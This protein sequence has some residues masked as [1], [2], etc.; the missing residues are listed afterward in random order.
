MNHPESFPPPF[1]LHQWLVQPALNRISG[2]EGPVQ[3][4]PRVMAVLLVLA[5]QPGE[6][7]TRLD[8]LDQVWG[9]AVVGEEILTRAISE[10]RRVFGDQA[11][12][13]QYIETIRNNGYRLIAP[14]SAP[15][16][17]I[18]PEE[19]EES[20]EP[21]KP[22]VPDEPK[23][24]LSEAAPSPKRR[25]PE[26]PDGNAA[27]AAPRRQGTWLRWLLV[28]AM[29]ATIALWGP[30][31]LQRDRAVDASIF[32]G[33]TAV[34]LTA[35]AGREYHP[36]LSP[37]GMRVAFAWSGPDDEHAAIH[38][39]QRNSESLLRLS[40]EPG[41]AAWPVWSPDGQSVAFVQ[42]SDT[43]STICL[44]PSIGGAVRRLHAVRHLIEGLDWSPDGSRLAFSA[45]KPN[46][47]YRL[48]LLNL[49]SLAT[50]EVPSDRVDNGG[51]FQPRFSPDGQQLAWIG[52]DRTGGS[53]VFVAPVVGGE[54]R[55]L[56]KGPDNR[57]GLAWTAD[58][59]ALVYAAA[60][61]GIFNLWRAPLDGGPA[62]LIP[63]PGDFAWNP[64]I[65][66]GSGDLVYEQVRVD[67]DL[68]RVSLRDRTTWQADSES[69]ITSTRWETGADFR[70]DG[71]AIA[72][73]SA[74][75]GNPEIWLS[76]V[77]GKNMR[78]L[79]SLKA[80]VVENLRWS[81][82]GDR[83]ACNAVIDGE[84]QILVV[85]PAGGVPRRITTGLGR[86][87]F[88]AWGATGDALLIGADAGSGWQVYR[89]DLQGGAASQVTR[90]GGVVAQEAADG[91]TLYFTRPDR[92][93]LWRRQ[94]GGRLAPELVL[95]DLLPRDRFNWRLVDDRIIWVMR[96]GGT[97]LLLEHDLS[98]GQSVLLVE[99]PGLQGAGVA[100]APGGNLFLYPKMGE[101][102]GD[103][104]LIAGPDGN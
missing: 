62:R 57:Q 46:G 29:L 2:S 40:D 31:L 42:T 13:P 66:R 83:L 50:T 6:L 33:P 59:Q 38:V 15:A 78:R 71:Q 84:Y 47:H 4:E 30:S 93:G 8:L 61:A 32:E 25:I 88:A 43:M 35:F 49:A 58:G 86:E 56:A 98:A 45:R 23:P 75:S 37:D 99:L 89:R 39:K 76:D 11:R 28:A 82:Q 87:V 69:F 63:T 80:A 16:E 74:R 10:L 5:E 44:V 48:F 96:T 95:A 12:Q 19:P 77:E 7:V 41:W 34:P 102:A 68:W 81:P 27:P 92:P 97:A 72:L 67:Q 104:M 52:R 79:T 9:D 1:C 21:E 73:V 20:E 91:R 94:S 54:A 85:E 17:A 65:A 26:T 101:A 18:L 103:L 55:V 60:P 53:G 100:V 36:A 14:L 22:V 70:P 24:E 64:T 51:D 90:G 3:I